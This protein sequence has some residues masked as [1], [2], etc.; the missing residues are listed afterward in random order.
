MR[1]ESG[2]P[3]LPVTAKVVV[4]PPP[5]TVSGADA[6]TVKNTRWITPRRRRRSCGTDW[7]SEGMTLL[8]RE[9]AIRPQ[10]VL[11]C[12]G[13]SVRSSAISQE[14][15]MGSWKFVVLV[16]EFALLV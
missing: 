12:R 6:A 14:P 13:L 1:N 2:T 10:K 11:H 9:T 8:V 5:N 15:L 7:R 3:E 4:T 16:G